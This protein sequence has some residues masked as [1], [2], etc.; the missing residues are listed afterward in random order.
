MGLEIKF[1]VNFASEVHSTYVPGLGSRGDDEGSAAVKDVGAT[2]RASLAGVRRGDG[3][4]G[5]TAFVEV[6]GAS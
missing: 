4:F 3:V 1:V 2:E 5:K 6:V